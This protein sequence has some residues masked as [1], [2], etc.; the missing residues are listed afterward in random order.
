MFFLLRKFANARSALA[1]RDIWRSSL[2]RQLIAAWHYVELCS[3][4]QVHNIQWSLCSIMAQ[5][6]SSSSSLHSSWISTGTISHSAELK[7]YVYLICLIF[8]KI[9]KTLSKETASCR[10]IL[11]IENSFNILT[12]HMLASSYLNRQISVRTQNSRWKNVEISE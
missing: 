4:V 1:L 3:T 8:Q 7:L 2:A 9:L 5:V 12:W 6:S 11:I 10:N